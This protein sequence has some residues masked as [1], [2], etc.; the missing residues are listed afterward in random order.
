MQ[1]VLRRWIVPLG[2]GL[3]AI[4]LL[5]AYSAAM[6]AETAILECVADAAA[7]GG[8]VAPRG[9]EMKMPGMILASFRTWNVTRWSVE[10]ATLLFH[11]ARGEA[12]TTVEIATIPQKWGEI[13]PP[14]L[15]AAK[16]TFLSQKA[17]AE[18]ENWMAIEVPGSMVEDMA[19]S[20]AHGLVIRLKKDL[21]VHSRESGT[22]SPYLIVMGTRR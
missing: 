4:F 12:P 7:S 16:L 10:N 5:L 17:S 6:S 2:S 1:R 13:E 9:R 21:T 14:R 20:R 18:P 19:A 22:F 8:A 11:I 3:P 15:D